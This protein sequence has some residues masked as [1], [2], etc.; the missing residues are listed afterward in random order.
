[1]LV[2]ELAGAAAHVAA[3]G[4]DEAAQLLR[5][6]LGAAEPAAARPAGVGL[7]HGDDHGED[8]AGDPGQVGGAGAVGPVHAPD[9]LV[10]GRTGPE[11]H[12][13]DGAAGGLICR[14]R[15]FLVGS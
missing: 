14:P 6:Q 12:G 11:A 4:A 1:V 3:G 5:R 8:G 13:G 9:V 10:A 2:D 15:G 7:V